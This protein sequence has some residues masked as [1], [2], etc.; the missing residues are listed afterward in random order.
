[1]KAV[2]ISLFALAAALPARLLHQPGRGELLA[3]VG[4]R[5]TYQRFGIAFERWLQRLDRLVV[6]GELALL[7][8]VPQVGLPPGPRTPNGPAVPAWPCNLY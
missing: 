6:Q 5:P 4:L 7:D 3:A 2:L 1:M 8:A